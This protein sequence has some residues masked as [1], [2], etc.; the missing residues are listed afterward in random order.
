M[1]DV[2]P[3]ILT[4]DPVEAQ[5][6]LLRAEKAA[7]RISIDI[8]DGEFA[9]NKTIDPTVFA[10]ISVSADLDFQLMVKEPVNWIKKCVDSGAD[11]VVGHVEMMNDQD[12][13]VGELNN[14]GVASGLAL[15]I[16][17]PVE[18]IVPGLLGFIS[19]IYLMSY[20]AGVGGQPFDSRVLDK[21]RELKKARENGE[22]N[23][24]IHVDG[25]INEKTVV[26]V[27]KAGADEV[28][29]GRSLFAGDM[30]EKINKLKEAAK[31]G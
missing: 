10:Q 3:S 4:A 22:R 1:V 28:S 16:D 30:L 23:Y 24:R 15:D 5:E 13:F 17:T 18:E 29:V 11:R 31:N 6:M 12:E 25:G 19:V 9:A 2:I 26:K 7:K 8:A 20:P 21:V 27:A 14:L